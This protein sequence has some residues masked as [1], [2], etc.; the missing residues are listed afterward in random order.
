MVVSG[1]S[2]APIFIMPALQN[3]VVFAVLARDAAWR[4]RPPGP[5]SAGACDGSGAA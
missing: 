5:R 3:L 1:L 4:V 2:E